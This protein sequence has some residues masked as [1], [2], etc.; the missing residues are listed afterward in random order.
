MITVPGVEEAGKTARSFMDALKDQPLSLALVVVILVLCFLLY[1]T[2]SQ[3]SM[4]RQQTT[5]T[6][7]RWQQDTDKLMAGCVSQDVTKL[8]IDNIQRVTETMLQTA[9]KDIER[10]QKAIDIERAN[11]QRIVEEQLKRLQ[12]YQPPPGLPFGQRNVAAP[13]VCDPEAPFCMPE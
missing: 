11:S 1:Y 7:I 3:T 5:E 13:D 6:I 9:Q 4:M 8:I 10:M 2:T 12:R